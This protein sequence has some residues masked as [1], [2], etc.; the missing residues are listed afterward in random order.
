MTDMGQLNALLT[1]MQIAPAMSILDF[2][3]GDGR[4]SEYI[5]DTTHTF[6]SGIDIADKAIALARERT[7]EKADRIHFYCTNLDRGQSALPNNALPNNAFDRIIAIDS[8]FFA[9]DQKAILETFLKYLK[10][11]GQLGLFYIFPPAPEGLRLEQTGFGKI[12][13]E[14]GLPYDTKDF[15][16]QNYEH[17]I[18]KKKVLLELEPM[19]YQEGQEFLFKNRMAECQG[20]LE[21]FHHYLFVIK[22]PAT[23]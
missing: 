16:A 11:D 9:K 23:C 10:K 12:V 21:N 3:C 15:T 1:E 14:L 13:N 4:I 6:V 19:F 18:K 7:K 22:I 8:L 5:A 17:W 20:G 2:G